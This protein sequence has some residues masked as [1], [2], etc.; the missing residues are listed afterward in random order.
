[1]SIVGVRVSS[2]TGQDYL[3]LRLIERI[4]RVLV[5]QVR[6]MTVANLRRVEVELVCPR[7]H[8]DDLSLVEEGLHLILRVCGD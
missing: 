2:D 4:L 5:L 1:M 6:N 7:H 8:I 3:M